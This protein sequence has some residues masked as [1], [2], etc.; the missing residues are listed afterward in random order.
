MRVQLLQQRRSIWLLVCSA[1]ASKRSAP[2]RAKRTRRTSRRVLLQTQCALLPPTPVM[3]RGIHHQHA[4]CFLSQP[5]VNSSVHTPSHPQMPHSKKEQIAAEGDAEKLSAGTIES[6]V[7]LLPSAFASAPAAAAETRSIYRCSAAPSKQS[8]PVILS[9]A[10]PNVFRVPAA[11]MKRDTHHQHSRIL[12]P[13]S[14][15]LLSPNSETALFVY[16]RAPTDAAC[17]EGADRC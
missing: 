15:C 11:V 10:H 2:H 16:T 6:Q 12:E 4:S 1:A 7:Q 13:C 3:K 9:S 8:D 14:R 17:Q 5:A